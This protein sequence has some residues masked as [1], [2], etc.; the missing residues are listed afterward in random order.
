[1][2]LALAKEIYG[3]TIWAVD[4]ATFGS[5]YQ[6]LTDIR[7]GVAYTPE[8]ERP[9]NSS[10]FY[11][12]SS[13]TLVED[14]WD[15]KNSQP[16]D[17]VINVMY[18]NG[19]VTKNGGASTRGTKRMS[20]KMRSMDADP[21]VKGH[22]LVVDSGGGSLGGV[23]FM[24]DAINDAEKPVGI[25]LEKSS[26]MASAAYA[27]GSAGDFIMSE[28]KEN[29]VGSLGMF[30]QLSGFP[31]DTTDSFGMKHLRIYATKSIRKN[32]ET[33]EAFEGNLQP[34]TE[35]VLDPANK[36]FLG[37]IKKNRPQITKN[38]TDG[39]IFLAGDVIGSMVDTIGT[40]NDAVDKV[41]EMSKNNSTTKINSKDM[42]SKELQAKYP[43]ASQEL[44]QAG[45]N[46]EFDRV[47]AW[48]AFNDVNPTA[49]TAGISSKKNPSQTEMAE[50][51]KEGKSANTVEKLEA[52]SQDDL[53]TSEQD[54]EKEEGKN[55][56]H[57][58]I[59]KHIKLQ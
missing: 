26:V 21:R 57:T 11:D 7:K 49:V 39:S 29:E 5:L 6:T 47:T 58:E 35:D 2:N 34:M 41:L 12:I 32:F 28:S 24:D 50:M 38:Q 55:S 25:F 59:S 40:F 37:N 27:I 43:E 56:L 54:S 33:E 42:T 19:V 31:K 20:S 36:L 3:N 1:M 13:A 51:Y 46:Q 22:I 14:E 4:S 17:E 30:A 44:V 23:P 8:N 18:L 15:L 45:I 16:E 53:E 9:Y 10:S 48:T 52:E